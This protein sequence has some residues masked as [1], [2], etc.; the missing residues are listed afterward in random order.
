[1]K[2][3]RIVFIRIDREDK[4][5]QA[6]SLFK[7]NL[8]R[9][10]S[11]EFKPS[12]VL[13][14]NDYSYDVIKKCYEEIEMDDTNWKLYFDR[15]KIL[16]YEV[17]YENIS[18]HYYECI[19]HCAEYITGFPVQNVPD[20]ILKKQSDELSLYFEQRFLEDAKKEL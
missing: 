7:G 18:E 10:W 6:I 20:P 19:S 9:S 16:P 11:S 5:K 13:S 3:E 15:N 8:T 1:M 2:D 17:I 14:E 12:I 4:V